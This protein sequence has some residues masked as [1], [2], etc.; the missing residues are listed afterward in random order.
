MTTT[1][2]GRTPEEMKKGLEC[3]FPCEEP[4]CLEC[5]YRGVASCAGTRMDDTLAYIQQLERER[6]A[7]I[8]DIRAASLSGCH[9]CKHYYQ[10]DPDKRVFACKKYGAFGSFEWLKDDGS[11]F[12]GSIEWRGVQEVN[13]NGE[14]CS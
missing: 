5:P 6:D 1:I 12:C 8:K 10:P 4:D 14:K 7:A 9:V 2:N 13:D 3:C 11:V